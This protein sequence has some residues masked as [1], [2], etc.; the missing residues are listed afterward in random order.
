MAENVGKR[1]GVWFFRFDLPPGSDGRRRQKR[2]SGFQSERDA[3]RALAR[4]KL[5]V[6]EGRLRHFEG[7]TVEDL[8]QEWLEAV[9]PNRKATTVANYTMLTKA[10]ILPWIGSKRLDRLCRGLRF[11]TSTEW[12]TISSTTQLVSGTSHETRQTRSRNL[13]ATPTSVPSIRPRRPDSSSL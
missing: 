6:G 9:G 12:S 5:D 7:R 10:Y 13:G 2:V 4:A 1:G 11:E 8:A 3:R